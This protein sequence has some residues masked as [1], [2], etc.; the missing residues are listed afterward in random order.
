[1]ES[2]EE[3]VIHNS[4]EKGKIEDTEK[5]CLCMKFSDEET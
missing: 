2:S 3:T 1:M 5:I 4:K